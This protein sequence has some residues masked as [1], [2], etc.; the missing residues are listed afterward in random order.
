MTQQAIFGLVYVSGLKM[1]TMTLETL[2]GL[3][4]RL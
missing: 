3:Q 2:S 1:L 4:E